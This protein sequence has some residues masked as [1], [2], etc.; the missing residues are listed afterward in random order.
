MQV[1]DVYLMEQSSVFPWAKC[2]CIVVGVLT[3]KWPGTMVY[4]YWSDEKHLRPMY[5]MV[6]DDHPG[7]V[8]VGRNAKPLKHPS[9]ARRYA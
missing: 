6:Q 7:A 8:L 2:W 1:G 3:G 4:V 5:M 9:K